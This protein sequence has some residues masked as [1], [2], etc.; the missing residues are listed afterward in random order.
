MHFL[1]YIQGS[2][3]EV[4]TLAIMLLGGA[5]SSF[6]KRIAS[7]RIVLGVFARYG[8]SVHCTLLNVI[9]SEYQFHV[10]HALVLAFSH[11]WFCLWYVL[12][13]H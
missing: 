9:G 8:C 4:S 5:Y 12:Y 1:G 10:R 11:R 6:I 13:G 3:G 2:V 7:W